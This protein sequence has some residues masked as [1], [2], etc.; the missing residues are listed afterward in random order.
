LISPL[1]RPAESPANRVIRS[2]G[3][4]GPLSA[5]SCKSKL[6]DT[7]ISQGGSR[8]DKLMPTAALRRPAHL[9]PS[10]CA[11]WQVPVGSAHRHMTPIATASLSLSRSFSLSVPLTLP[12]PVPSPRATSSGPSS[13]QRVTGRALHSQSACV[14]RRVF[15][16]CCTAGPMA[17][18]GG[19]AGE[20]LPPKTSPYLME[21]II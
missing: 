3:R 11:P 2:G 14:W 13:T 7:S 1:T 16:S 12:Q 10:L 19:Q 17:Q 6:D 15:L 18:D 20:S 8:A 4:K 9:S 5:S 21:T